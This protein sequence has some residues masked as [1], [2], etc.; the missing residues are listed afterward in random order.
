M[1]RVLP[2][3]LLLLLPLGAAPFALTACEELGMSKKRP[4]VY[5]NASGNDGG[6][7]DEEGGLPTG[8]GPVITAQPGD[9]QL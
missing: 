6:T 5:P 7:S 4:V 8:P 2:P 3:L 9:I 1:K